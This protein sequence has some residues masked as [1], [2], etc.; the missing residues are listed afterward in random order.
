M[1]SLNFF[2]SYP[3]TDKLSRKISQL[4][5]ILKNIC[6]IFMEKINWKALLISLAVSLGTGALSVLLTMGGMSEYVNLYK[7][8]LSPPGW[9]FPVVWTILYILMGIAAYL[10][11]ESEGEDKQSALSLYGIQLILNGAWS[12]FFFGRGAY[13]LALADL[14]LLWLAIYLTIKQFRQLNE[15]AAKLLIPYLIWV[16]FAG[17]LNLAIALY[18]RG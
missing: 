8:P 13:F 4:H 7:P 9:L 2:L 14:L 16:T 18:Y 3:K 11:W 12:V 1:V 17:Y 6:G 5:R 10:I 15:I